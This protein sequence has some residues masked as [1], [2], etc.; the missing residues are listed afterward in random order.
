MS[1][2]NNIEELIKQVTSHAGVEGFI[3]VNNEGIPIRHSFAEGSRL[4]AIQY[5]APAA[6][7][8]SE[9]KGRDS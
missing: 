4:L 3:I 7:A 9:G 1:A 8:R 6:A 5:A 2:E